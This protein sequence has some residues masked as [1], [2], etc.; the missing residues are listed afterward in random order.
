LGESLGIRFIFRHLENKT[1]ELLV[2]SDKKRELENF[3]K[4]LGRKFIVQ[5]GF[6]TSFKAIK[7]IGKGMTACVYNA[8]SFANGK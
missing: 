1:I 8:I 7:R 3:S 6:H 4:I 5:L 2:K